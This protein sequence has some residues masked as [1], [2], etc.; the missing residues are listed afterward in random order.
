MGSGKV[1]APRTAERVSPH[2]VLN[3]VLE[4]GERLPCLVDRTTW[5][6]VRVGTRWAV[7]YRR[8]RVQSST[9]ESN[10]RVLGRIYEWARRSAGVD[11]DDQLTSGNSLTTRQIESMVLYFHT[12]GEGAEAVVGGDAGTLDHH[13]S[14]AENFLKWALDSDNRGGVRTLTLEE[15]SAQRAHLEQVFRSLR[16]GTKQS[17]RIQPLSE[18]ELA[19]LR[20][21]LAPKTEAG[22]DWVFPKGVFYRHA[23]LR[24]WLMVETGL[25]LGLRRGE[26]LKLRL[27]S[28]PRG[29]DDGLRVLRRPDDPHDSRQREPA[30]KTAERVVPVSRSLLSLFRAY[31]ISKPPLGRVTGKT[32][33]LFVT[34]AGAPLS[35]KAADD[36]MRTIGRHSGV[37]PLSWHRLRHTWAERMAEVLAEQANGMDKL[38]Y[39]GGWTNP[40]SPK[41]YTQ[42]AIARQ[43]SEA[44]RSYHSRLYSE[45]S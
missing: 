26:L 8:Y 39:L 15:L 9:L 10:L 21:V 20:R 43:A 24:N 7:R 45:D 31:L 28:I 13:V 29:G 38:V 41:R 25:E 5:I 33:Y 16:T 23:Q 18:Q 14:V 32:P 19:S 3:V 37:T 40:Q 6:P 12:R 17:Q 1:D 30:V 4:S 34:G 2:V 35:M 27:D 42:N 22:R 11:L 36:I 44:M